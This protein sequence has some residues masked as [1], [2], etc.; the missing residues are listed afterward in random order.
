MRLG[1][2][3]SN[4]W[5]LAQISNLAQYWA[6]I[7]DKTWAELLSV[8][9]KWHIIH[10]KRC[11]MKQKIGDQLETCSNS[12]SGGGCCSCWCCCDG[13]GGGCRGVAR[14]IVYVI[15][16]LCWGVKPQSCTGGRWQGDPIQTDYEAC[17]VRV[18]WVS[19]VAR[20]WRSTRFW[21]FMIRSFC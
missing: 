4:I 3:G 5:K 13:G 9:R 10:C 12:S 16:C 18:S 8:A 20:C 2:I 19:N 7:D 6:Q 21:E 11:N 14:H 15:T 1:H 17:A